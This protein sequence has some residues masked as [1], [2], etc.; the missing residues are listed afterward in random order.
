MPLL[1]ALAA[2]LFGLVIS[3]AAVVVIGAQATAMIITLTHIGMRA[4]SFD[5]CWSFVTT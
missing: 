5:A 3:K 1:L 2:T 4:L